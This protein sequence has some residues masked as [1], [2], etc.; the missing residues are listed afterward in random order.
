MTMPTQPT[1]SQLITIMLGAIAKDIKSGGPVL[2]VLRKTY[3]APPTSAAPAT[4]FAGYA[5][6]IDRLRLRRR[7][8]QDA[9]PSLFAG[10]TERDKGITKAA[11]CRNELVQQVRRHLETV[12]RG[13]SNR[14][15]TIDDAARILELT[16]KTAR[17]LGNAAGAVF[18]HEAWECTGLTT[19][20]QRKSSHAR[21][22]LVW[23]L[24]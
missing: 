22:I 19:M 20:S 2:N 11:E 4:S 9:M 7:T 5:A 13:R 17:D 15:V 14:C 10:M 1:G 3:G 18:K 21:R 23:R 12:A 8:P 6:S 24:R 16:G